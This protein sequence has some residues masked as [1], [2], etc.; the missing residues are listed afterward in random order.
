VLSAFETA[1]N[2]GSATSRR[3][4]R[5]AAHSAL[6][7]VFG[8]GMAEKPA[9]GVRGAPLPANDP[10]ARQWIVAVLDNHFSGAL[11]AYHRPRDGIDEF[12]AVVTHDRD[13]VLAIAKPLLSRLPPRR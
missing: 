8:E 1:E 7:A 5:L 9:V 4:E 6:V 13:L 12:D 2:F 3:Y 10:V 11:A